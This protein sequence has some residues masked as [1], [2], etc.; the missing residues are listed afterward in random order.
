MAPSPP[1]APTTGLSAM[2]AQT[3]VKSISARLMTMKFMQ[4]AVASEPSSPTT[5]NTNESGS[6]KRRKVSHTPV[7]DS[8]RTP[9]FDVRA[10]QAAIEEEEKKREAAVA[11]LALQL[12]DSHWVLEGAPKTTKGQH[13]PLKVVQVG[14]AQ[15]DSSSL[16]NETEDDVVQGKKTF[17]A[18]PV[19]ACLNKEPG[20]PQE[21]RL[22][23]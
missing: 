20:S 10:A 18:Q 11:K 21:P 15:I 1:Q 3:P 8:P 23:F 12:G 22:Q 7:S 16:S 17:G 14:F 4:R 19:K 2:A 6:G 13:I 5:P 9:L